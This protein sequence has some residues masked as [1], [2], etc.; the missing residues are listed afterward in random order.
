MCVTVVE[1]VWL[2]CFRRSICSSAA[3][4]VLPAG[5]ARPVT[6]A[7]S[8]L[9]G[10]RA[11]APGRAS[12]WAAPTAALLHSWLRGWRCGRSSAGRLP[13]QISLFPPTWNWP[14]RLPWFLGM[15]ASVPSHASCPVWALTI[16][17]L[18]DGAREPPRKRDWFSEPPALQGPDC[19]LGLHS[20]EGL[21]EA[22]AFATIPSRRASVLLAKQPACWA[23]F[24]SFLRGLAL[25]H[26]LPANSL[27]PFI[28]TFGHQ[29]S[30]FC[31]FFLHG[32]A[33]AVPF[34]CSNILAC[35]LVVRGLVQ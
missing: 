22:C 12:Q 19:D 4:P 24:P 13:P 30:H 14:P 26:V 27:V 31:H 7:G 16:L 2:T 1:R 17:A 18:H 8:P 23:C 20:P 9:R 28:L 32:S 35:S 29:T 25:A 10:H 6:A 11:L 21:P 3:C 5:R 15:F 33:S 34:R